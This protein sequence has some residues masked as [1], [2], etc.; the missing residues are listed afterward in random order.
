MLIW[1]CEPENRHTCILRPVFRPITSY[2]E[3]MIAAVIFR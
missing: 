2:S 3:Q 1:K